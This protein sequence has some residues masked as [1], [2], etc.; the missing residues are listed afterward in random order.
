MK[1]SIN[2]LKEYINID[3]TNEQISSALTASG[4]EVEGLE[5]VEQVK[6]NLS[7][8]V[9]GKVLTCEK[10]PGA[11]K[12]SKTTVDLGDGKVTPIVC[13]APNVA[14]GQ[15]VLVAT[16]GTMLHSEG[17]EPFKIKKAK[18]RGE[19]SEGMICAEDE[20]GLG[21][22][23]DGIMVLDT[24]LPAGTPAA[25][26]LQLKTDD[27]L[28]IGLTPN[29]VDAASHIGVARDL[30]AMYGQPVN[31][32]SVDAFEV[33]NN[34][35]P[36]EVE[37]E[38]TVACPRYSAVTIS[39]VEVKESPEWLKFRLKAIG[40]A[41]INNVVDA[42]NYV[43]HETGQPL[44]AFDAEGVKGNK[45][46]VKNLPEGTPFTT[47]DEKERKLHA[48]DLMVCN[49][50]E[51]MCIAGVFG[52]MHSGVKENTKNIFLESAYFAADSVRK[53]SQLHT[54]KTDASFRFERGTD[55]NLTVYALKRAALLI[56]ELA[57]GAI[58][59][60]VVD[61]YP[62]PAEDFRVAVKYANVDRLI[63]KKLEKE[64]IHT[65]LEN[66]D[67]RVTEDAPE[68]FVAVVSPYRV[69][70][71]READ[72]IEE[73]LRIYGYDNVE[74]SE[75]LNSDFLAHFPEKDAYKIE[76]KVA[77]LLA[78][79]GFY[80][81]MTNSLTSSKFTA[82]Q[83]NLKPEENVEILNRLSEDLD[84]MRQTLLF[85]HLDV[86]ARNVN[87]KQKDLKLFEFGKAYFKREGKYVEEN[88]LALLIS[89]KNESESWKRQAKPSTYYDL[90]EALSKIFN[91]FS[92]QGY[93][94]TPLEHPAFEYGMAVDVKG[95]E[96]VRAGLL[97]PQLLKSFGLKEEV[98]YAD[99]DWDFFV[100][101]VG[102]ELKFEELSKFP[103]V[104]RDLSLVIDQAVT[105]GQIMAVAK[106]NAGHLITDFN[107]FDVYQGDKVEAG[108]KAYAL[109]FTLKDKKK[110]LNDKAI[111]KTMKRLIRAF[112]QEVGAVIR[113]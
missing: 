96:L 99:I 57:G 10:H 74:V 30:R 46:V 93:E 18:I 27:V 42:T 26:F 101:L 63:G 79:N 72:V 68:G 90:S 98:F 8:V 97:T 65:I 87:R 92:L 22:S 103:E 12:L 36:I 70:V 11:D 58:S 73:I 88:R 51:P 55:P 53:T 28:E 84:V 33:E 75:A 105:Y 76:R 102:G 78:D 19:V 25:D 20:L 49:S 15:K 95:K 80:E 60:D 1:I 106:K 62:S 17:N 69:D 29:R 109:S 61:V 34:S 41:P 82:L 110:T 77:S 100:E 24:D 56:K 71:T 59:S 81:M 5:M 64:Q 108:K 86:V 85:G 43:L 9:I 52:G 107:C 2:W 48:S 38:N 89:G 50:E 21:Q 35:L 14:A 6:G 16:V 31:W 54:L 91:K 94:T 7:G 4:L 3:Q 32:P 13:G 39:G 37:V 67:I 66:L 113:Q 47:L 104:K 83:P 44:H 45:V 40:L 111:E 23:H 112:E